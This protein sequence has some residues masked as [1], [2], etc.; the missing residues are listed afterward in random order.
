[1][2]TIFPSVNIDGANS[3]ASSYRPITPTIVANKFSV[4]VNNCLD[5]TVVREYTVTAWGSSTALFKPGM[6]KGQRLFVVNGPSSSQNFT[7]PAATTNVGLAAD[8]AL[9]PKSGIG[10]TWNGT[11]WICTSIGV[12]VTGAAG[13]T[14][15][16]A[17][18]GLA[19]DDH[20]QYFTSGRADTW[21]LGKALGSLSDVPDALG[22]PGT[23]PPCRSLRDHD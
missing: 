19:D 6:F 11:L 1:M 13:V 15:H 4:D 18:T 21:F 3:Y 17:L 9:A 8:T 10:F 23:L 5:T 14:D 12:A 22:S 20:P 16:G 7:V 2:V